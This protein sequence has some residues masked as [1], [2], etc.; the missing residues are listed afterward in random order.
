[1]TSLSYPCSQVTVILHIQSILILPEKI[2]KGESNDRALDGR[3]VLVIQVMGRLF[4]DAIDDPFAS[5]D[6]LLEP[7]LLGATVDAILV[8]SVLTGNA[9]EHSAGEGHSWCALHGSSR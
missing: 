6:A 3:K 9:V 5:L 8:G 1:M 4:M 7:Y 2:L